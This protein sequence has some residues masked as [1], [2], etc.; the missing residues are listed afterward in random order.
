M[1]TNGNKIST[2]SDALANLQTYISSN[3]VSTYSD[4][5]KSGAPTLF[6]LTKGRGDEVTHAFLWQELS[7]TVKFLNVGKSMNIEQVKLTAQYIID[8]YSNLNLL[9]FKL[10]FAKFRKGEFGQAYDRIDG[11]LILQALADYKSGRI[12]AAEQNSIRQAAQQKKEEKESPITSQEYIDAIKAILIDV[13]QPSNTSPQKVKN[14]TQKRSY[15]EWDRL[16][17]RW[18]K[19]F[20]NLHRGTRL[21]DFR[22]GESSVWMIKVGKLKPLSV[23]EFLLY[24]SR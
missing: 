23:N 4:V 21:K 13:K 14:V 20:Y 5:L 6:D 22:F 18:M 12:E 15:A 2:K 3:K 11:Q 9:D 8:D 19:Q 24:K 10:F 7:N 1:E 16:Q 17:Q